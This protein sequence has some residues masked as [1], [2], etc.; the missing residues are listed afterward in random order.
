MQRYAYRNEQRPNTAV[1]LITPP[2]LAIG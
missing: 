2:T 1:V